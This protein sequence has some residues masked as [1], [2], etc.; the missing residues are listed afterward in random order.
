M[1]VIRIEGN[2][3]HAVHARMRTPS[4]AR[5]RVAEPDYQDT[6][7]LGRPL[8]CCQVDQL[9]QRMHSLEADLLRVQSQTS[10]TLAVPKRSPAMLALRALLAWHMRTTA[11]PVLHRFCIKTR[12]LLCSF[13]LSLFLDQ[14]CIFTENLE[15]GLSALVEWV[16]RCLCLN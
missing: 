12:S 10:A 4:P 6:L 8:L 1:V 9:A 13:T 16:L 14:F 2:G 5:P 7:F 11:V 3:K 15:N